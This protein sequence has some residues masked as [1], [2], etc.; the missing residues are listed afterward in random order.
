M[1]TRNGYTLIELLVVIGLVAAL[2][3]LT[4][5]GVQRARLAALR[6]SCGNNLRQLALALHSHHDTAGTL[7]PAFR[8]R[9]ATEPMRYLSWRVALLP[10]LEQQ[11]LWE[12]TEAAY[13]IERN[14]FRAPHAPRAQVLKV[15]G[16]PLDERIAV[17]W[18]VPPL[19]GGAPIRTAL[20]SYLGV[21]GTTSARA[22][23]VLYANSRTHLLHITDGTS[24]T[25]MLGERPPSTDLVY[26]WW[27]AGT[28]QRRTGQADAHLGAAERNLLGRRYRDCGPGPYAFTP[29]DVRDHC[30][31]F[32]FWS[33]HPGGAHF[34]FADG[35][36]RFL[37]HPTSA[38]PELATRAGGE[39]VPGAE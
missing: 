39:V 28:G 25:L 33:R 11:A 7:P 21:S 19:N 4:L 16:C 3:G 8:S 35:S 2:V 26:G 10:H 38:L 17:A 23:G 6:V 14:P 27:Y 1:R 9:P 32:K 12:A 15:F 29:G 22:D 30:S 5:V 34:A 31:A 18:D 20:S 13:R 36:V 37:T 24:N